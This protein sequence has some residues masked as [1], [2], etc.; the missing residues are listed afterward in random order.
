[1]TYFEIGEWSIDSTFVYAVAG[2][3][4]ITPS[5]GFIDLTTSLFFG[6]GGAVIYQQA[7]RFNIADLAWRICWVDNGDTFATRSVGGLVGTIVTGLF[8]RKEVAAYDGATIDGG[9]FFDGNVKQLWIQILEALAGSTRSFGGSYLVFALI[10]RVPG[11][12]FLAENE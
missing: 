7:L 2:L 5:A 11:L 3:V 8:A 10:D 12:V 1:M 6:A 4:L 9:I